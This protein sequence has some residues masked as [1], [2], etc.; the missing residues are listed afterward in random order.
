L[1]IATAPGAANH[2]LA[3]AD[4]RDW[5]VRLPEMAGIV[6]RHA[7]FSVTV[8]IHSVSDLLFRYPQKVTKNEDGYFFPRDLSISRA[9]ATVT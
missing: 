2:W 7:A 9:C 6:A 5:F 8:P 1:Q 4:S 3:I